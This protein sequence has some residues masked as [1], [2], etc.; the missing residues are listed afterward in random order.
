[1]TARL[2]AA[3][4]S[5]RVLH[6]DHTSAAGGAQFAL[7]RMLRAEP[8]WRPVLSVPPTGR[9]G[10]YAALPE[11]I[12][13]RVVGIAQRAG[14]SAGGVGASAAAALRLALQA[15]ATRLDR[16][17]RTAEVVDA[18][19]ARA[20][21]YGALAALT[22]RVPFVIHLRDLVE[23]EA[24]GG[25]GHT[26]M[27]RVALPRADGVV[28]NSRATL[29]S[30]RPFL[31]SDTVTAII[32]SASGLTRTTPLPRSGPLRVGMVARIDPWKGQAL[33]LEAFAAAFADGDQ[34]LEFAG[35][36]PFG[37]DAYLSELR[38]L[39]A[40]LGVEARVAFLG[41]VEDVPALLARWDIAVQASLRPE[42]LG[43]NVLQ[44]LATGRATVV[45]DEG[46]PTEWVVHEENGLR[47]AP[48]DKAALAT[49]L[50]RLH[51]NPQLRTRLAHAAAETPGL[52]TDREV[53]DAHAAFY[54]DVLAR[55]RP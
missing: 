35:S 55:P 22:A 11:R 39:A 52:R 36:A 3:P 38:S 34:Q 26:L 5:I 6:L 29:E 33:L 43:Q 51:A 48:R 50:Q 24:L 30:A 2:D 7:V 53:A 42:P 23:P 18:N 40:R 14:V 16:A 10:V 41:H 46:G 15:L 47:F 20:A 21:A 19:T 25:L 37:H 32:P 12:P 45:A 13:M 27:T 54:A 9:G 8:S 49:A 1:M 44:Y 31:R 28:A 4:A 17:F